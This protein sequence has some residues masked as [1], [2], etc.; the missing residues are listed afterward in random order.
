VGNITHVK[1]IIINEIS[2]YDILLFWKRSNNGVQSEEGQHNMVDR[3]RKP[4]RV[5]ISLGSTN[6]FG[7]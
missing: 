6:T 5:R 7:E 3:V 1:P 2:N 4:L